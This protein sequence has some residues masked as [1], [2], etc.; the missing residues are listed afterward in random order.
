MKRAWSILLSV[1]LGALVVGIGT[2]YFLHLANKDRQSL[3]LEAKEAN[4]K[5]I[6][7][8][9][10]HQ[11]AIQEA[12]RKLEQANQE[13]NKAQDA[14]KALE[15]ERT[16]L[17]QAQPLIPLPAQSTQD[18]QLAL[19][20]SLGIALRFPPGSA[21]KQDIENRLSVTASGTQAITSQA[22]DGPWID[23]MPFD[24]KSKDTLSARLTTSTPI[25][26]FVNGHLL[27]GLKG[28][29]LDGAN[30]SSDAAVLEV[31]QNGSTTHLIW[32]Q[33][34]PNQRPIRKAK[35]ITLQDVL[36]TLDFP[37]QP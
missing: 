1:L 2:G 16:L 14:I 8:Q 24:K 13:V 29:L 31:Y 19:S 15:R 18:W 34:P 27:D 22:T 21:I 33:T 26:Y 23:I 37:K 7:I 6:Q 30:K 35:P 12:N 10:D 36:A 17:P 5:T 20:A 11:K 4:D 25:T 9:Q 3:A 32:I 28:S